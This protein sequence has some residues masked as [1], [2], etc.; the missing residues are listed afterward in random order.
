MPVQESPGKHE[1]VVRAVRR[2]RLGIVVVDVPIDAEMI[3]RLH[4]ATGVKAGNDHRQ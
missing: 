4:D 2:S 1:L 3:S